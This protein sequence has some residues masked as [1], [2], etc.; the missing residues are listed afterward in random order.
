MI[1]L[2]E[3][4]MKQQQNDLQ[5]QKDVFILLC[6]VEKGF[7]TLEEA[8][9]RVTVIMQEHIEIW[10]LDDK[11]FAQFGPIEINFKESGELNTITVTA[12]YKAFKL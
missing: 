10:L 5:N 1:G 11:A 6:L 8:K 2:Q 12:E 7:T 3:E 4:L 9:E